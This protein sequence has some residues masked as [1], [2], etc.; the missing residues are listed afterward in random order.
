F[1]LYC[2]GT[3]A[4]RSEQGSGVISLPEDPLTGVASRSA[5]AEIAEYFRGRPDDETWSMVMIDI[6]SF[7]LINDVYG[8]LTGD[9]VLRQLAD[10]IRRNIRLRDTV[11]RYGDDEFLVIMPGTDGDGALDFYQRLSEETTKMV[12][13]RNLE[14]S[15]SAGIAQSRP[16][17]ERLQEVSERADQS[18]L[19]AKSAGKSRV[20]FNREDLTERERGLELTHFVGRRKELKQLRDALREALRGGTRLS[21]VS[22]EAGVGKSRLLAELSEYA[23]FKGCSILRSEGTPFSQDLPYQLVLRPVRQAL[24]QLD[25]DDLVAIREELGS[26]HPATAELLPGFWSKTGEDTQYLNEDSLRF[27]IFED[28]G[29][30]VG[31][32]SDRTPVMIVLEN[33]QWAAPTDIDLVLFLARSNPEAPILLA[34]TIRSGTGAEKDMLD[35]LLSVRGSIPVTHVA[36]RNLSPTETENLVM[37]TLRDPDVPAELQ[38]KL[39]S[40]SGGNPL[41]LRELLHSLWES[42]SINADRQDMLHYDLPKTLGVPGS[43][44]QI[45]TRKLSGLDDRA[46]RILEIASLTPDH[47]ELDLLEE[48]TDTDRFVLAEILDAC[49]RRGILREERDERKRLCFGFALSAVRSYLREQLSETLARIYHGKMAEHLDLR[50]QSGDGHLL[51]AVAHHYMKAGEPSRSAL[52][53]MRAA[54]NAMR[55]AARRS[56]VE[57]LEKYLSVIEQPDEPA[58]KVAHANIQLGR[59]YTSLGELEKGRGYLEASL[60]DASGNLETQ[61]MV[62]LG[63]NDYM[64]SNYADAKANFDRVLR[65]SSD[66]AVRARVEIRTAFII[67]LEGNYEEALETLSRAWEDIESI[68]AVDNRRDGLMALYHIRRG[69]ILTNLC[70]DM[71]PAESYEEALRLC[72]KQGDRLGEAK[73]LNNMSELLQRSG[74]YERALAVLKEVEDI[75]GRFDNALGLAIV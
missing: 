23:A 71:S 58:G 51:A 34:G 52:Y 27:R 50:L 74:E 43:L 1:W 30:L 25:H 65:R 68:P 38:S 59:L 8:H 48:I 22:G 64:Q 70:S 36:L 72:R 11:L 12:F 28:F 60:A 9:S 66:P 40:H 26:I 3:G 45:I 67:N 44:S 19:S 21:L 41:F 57:W 47:F 15:V 55:R 31:I 54:E 2:G 61:A 49:C 7:G 62:E 16:G 37:F 10:L 33:L 5:L 20:H 39:Y 69:D 56:A 42:G 53:C 4:Q 32:L 17:D 24:G 29:R 6:D 13:H 18:L 35:G 46:V 75:N 73:A 63:E 14:V